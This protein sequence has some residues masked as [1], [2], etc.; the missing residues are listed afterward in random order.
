[1]KA[2]A[3]AETV[4]SPKFRGII[5]TVPVVATLIRGNILDGFT[6]IMAKCI[7]GFFF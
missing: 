6:N 5:L 2:I 1:M 4:Y 3:I 7:Q